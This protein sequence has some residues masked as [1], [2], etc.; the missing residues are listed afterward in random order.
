MARNSLRPTDKT[1]L[2]LGNG[3][4]G[5]DWTKFGIPISTTR[6]AIDLI[7]SDHPLYAGRYGLFTDIPSYLAVKHA[8]KIICVGARLDPGYAGYDYANFASHAHK[9]VVD[10]DE[11][12][13]GKSKADI[14][15]HMSAKDFYEKELK[16]Q[17]CT[18]WIDQIHAWQAK[19]PLKETGSYKV[20][21]EISDQATK[22]DIIV[23]DTSFSFHMAAQMWKI[24]KGQRYITTGGISTMGYWP[25]AIGAAHASGRRVLCITGDGCLQMNIQELATVVKNK[26]NIKIFVFNNDGYLLIRHTQKKYFNRVMG[27]S[28]KTGLGFPDFGE[29]AKAYDIFYDY[30]ECNG[31]TLKEDIAYLMDSK[32]KEPMLIEV[33]TPKWEV[34]QGRLDYITTLQNLP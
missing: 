19:Y 2:I 5:L 12:E 15:Y 1:L 17:D 24:K 22:D 25:A 4:R 7:E 21:K 8:E 29:I 18:D 9:T 11:N 27:E 6:L 34:P 30:T 28:P 16:P 10:I 14:K 20:I 32:Y 26:L 23:V 31:L 3:A 13:L 33:V